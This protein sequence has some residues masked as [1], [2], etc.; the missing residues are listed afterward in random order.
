MLD[1]WEPLLTYNSPSMNK[2]VKPVSI[3]FL[4]KIFV[5]EMPSDLSSCFCDLKTRLL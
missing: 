5:K 4:T 2:S 1:T 3:I